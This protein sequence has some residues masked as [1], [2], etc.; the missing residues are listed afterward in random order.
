MI[1]QSEIVSGHGVSRDPGV[2]VGAWIGEFNRALREGSE[3]DLRTLFLPDSHWRNVAGLGSGIVTIS[4][5]DRLV[6]QLLKCAK[7]VSAA[8]F[9]IAEGRVPPSSG[10]LA[11]EDFIEAMLYFDTTATT[12]IAHVRLKA[13]AGDAL[14]RAW[15][16][17][18]AIDTIKGHD[19]GS[20]RLA[21]DGSSFERD[22]NG[23][24]WAD[25]RRVDVSYTDHDPEV[26]VVG[27]GHGGLTAAAWLKAMNIDNLVV[28]RHERIGDNWRKRYRMLKLHSP[29]ASIDMSFMPFPPTWPK[30]IP[31]DKI[32]NW[33]ECYVET[34]EIN[35]WASTSFEGAEYD[36]ARRRWN[37]RLRLADGSM[38]TMHP[39]HIIMAT[40]QIGIPHIP[41]IPAIERFGGVVMHSSQ[42]TGGSDWT[43]KN[44]FVFGTGTSAHDHS[45]E[46][47]ANGAHVTM[48][49]R[50]ETEVIQVE[51][52]AHMYLDE[53]YE[54]SGLPVEDLDVLAC[55]VPLEVMKKEHQRLTRIARVQDRELL[56]GLQRIG[57][58]LKSDPDS[59][60]W[61]MK[62]S[63]RG[64]G[65]YF[66]VGGSDLLINREVGL[67]QYDDIATFEAEGIRMKDGSLRNADLIILA[68]GYKGYDDMTRQLFGKDVAERIG[69]VWGIDPERGEL[70]NMWIE[71]PQPGLWFAGGSFIHSRIY[72]K[73]IALQ[74]KLKNLTHA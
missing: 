38:R 3:D 30:Y 33:F 41:E 29:T 42:F 67:L 47:H 55:S 2:M 20:E 37:V 65:Y 58:R 17:M 5:A 13:S 23:P 32:A 51:P 22:W 54:V 57:F 28:D 36:G 11:D 35:Y 9:R 71:T 43:G 6:P 40:S 68:T 15:T 53:M 73:Y 16:F 31:K 69:S 61:V 21:R 59:L 1:V 25:R 39:A 4:G 72:A 63:T 48:V 12:G 8:D 24:N 45:Q 46:L 34:M 27:G 44:V 62:Y 7:A 74:I 50:G 14:P 66:N 70:S 52:S 49:Q 19:L 10:R 60:G 56:E 64:G 18:T 26:L